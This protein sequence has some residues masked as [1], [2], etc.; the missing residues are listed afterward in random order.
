MTTKNDEG[1]QR[2]WPSIRLRLPPGE[3]RAVETAAAADGRSINSF[4]RRA[5]AAA[6]AIAA[7]REVDQVDRSPAARKARAAKIREASHGK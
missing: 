1:V 4:I 3:K 6:V 2:D 5:L 7:K